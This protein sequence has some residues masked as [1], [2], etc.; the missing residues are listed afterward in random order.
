MVDIMP[1]YGVLSTRKGIINAHPNSISIP[2]ND[3][4]K[5]VLRLEKSEIGFKSKFDPD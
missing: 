3:D 1:V 2:E 4:L 5:F